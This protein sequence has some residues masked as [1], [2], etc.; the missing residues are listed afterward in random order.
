MSVFAL[1][2]FF[3]AEDVLLYIGLTTN[4]PARLKKHRD[5]KPWWQEIRQMHVEYHPTISALQAAER[6]A[7]TNEK[8]K[9]NVQHNRGNRPQNPVANHCEPMHDG[10][11]GRFFHSWRPIKEDESEHA[12]I[13]GNLVLEWQG[14]VVDRDDTGYIVELF[15]W[16]D[17]YPNG[18]KFVPTNELIDWTF[19]DSALE[20]QVS[21]R[22]RET[23]GRGTCG[24]ECSHVAWIDNRPTVTICCY[25][26]DSYSKVTA[27]VW[28]DGKPYLK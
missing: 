11:V 16:W 7:I 13:R 20:M 5:E 22:C 15:S 9:Y 8:P 14:R 6:E 12:T 23:Y 17:G 24:D 26:A 28:R 25:C 4:P 2:R 19:Y 21:L 1:Y 10:L 27:I 18:Q 3:D